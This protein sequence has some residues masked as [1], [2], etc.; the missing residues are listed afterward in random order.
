M[1]TLDYRRSQDDRAKASARRV[2]RLW[3]AY[4]SD[5][6]IGRNASTHCRPCAC[7]ACK[8]STSNIKEMREKVA[9]RYLKC[10]AEL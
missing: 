2:M 3:K 5:R 9:M 8:S 10:E 4:L 6:N 1:R 7:F